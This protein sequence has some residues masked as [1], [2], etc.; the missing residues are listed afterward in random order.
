M[1]PVNATM[2]EET[3]HISNYGDIR[4]RFRDV[5]AV[6]RMLTIKQVGVPNPIN[7]VGLDLETKS[8]LIF[9]LS[10]I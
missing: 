9:F 6:C 3:K 7:N 1:G 8:S 10:D 2:L 4:L 5:V